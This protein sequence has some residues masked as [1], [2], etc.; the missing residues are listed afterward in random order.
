MRI[1]ITS[2]IDMQIEPKCSINK[3]S[4]VILHVLHLQMCQFCVQADDASYYSP[5]KLFD[6]IIRCE[7]PVV[8]HNALVDLVYLYQNFYTDTPSS[9]Q[10]LTADLSEVILRFLHY[11]SNDDIKLGVK[12]TKMPTEN[13]IRLISHLFK[14]FV[15]FQVFAG[16]VYDTKYICEFK[17]RMPASYLEYIFRKRQVCLCTTSY[18]VRAHCDIVF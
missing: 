4:S 3:T 17:S 14:A 18:C 2:D 6:E 16:G 9:L 15:C 11:T 5:R 1:L 7:V 12:M 10:K 8:L 13:D